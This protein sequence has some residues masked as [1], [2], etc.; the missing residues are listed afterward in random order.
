MES[1]EKLELFYRRLLALDTA[2]DL[3]PLI[4]EA[5]TLLGEVTAS[6]L[7]YV[8]IFAADPSAPPPF[9]TSRPAGVATP[10]SRDIIRATVEERVAINVGSMLCAPILIDEPVGMLCIQRGEQASTLLDTDRTRAE[11]F[12]AR[13][14]LVADRIRFPSARGHVTLDDEI[15]RLEE[16]VVR[17]QLARHAGNISSAARELGTTRPRLY[18]IMKRLKARP[19]RRPT[20][21]A[22]YARR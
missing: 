8:E 11:L 18:R 15:H 17:A 21:P 13:L 3:K 14:A 5:V 10:V 4:A 9:T 19:R 1:T 20:R 22:V 2:T 12:A 6:D 7:V 16:R